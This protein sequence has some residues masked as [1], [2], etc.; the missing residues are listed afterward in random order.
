VILPPPATPSFQASAATLVPLQIEII[1]L[2][3][4]R[5]PS[6]GLW[7]V[8]EVVNR[9]HLTAEN[10][11]LQ[12]GLSDV[13][14]RGIAAIMTWVTPGIIG[15]EIKAPFGVLV[16]G[17]GLDANTVLA[18]PSAAVI[19]GQTLVDAGNR[20]LDLAVIEP[21][22]TIEE[23]QVAVQGQIENTGS[24]RADNILLVTT[25]YDALGNVT[26]FHELS[27]DF[28]LEPGERRPFSFVAAPPGGQVVEF[29]FLAQGL[30]N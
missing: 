30:K 1:N 23:I 4:Y 27:L 21:A 26:G 3:A 14:G 22:A 15:P 20:Y 5:T 29:N 10:I 16:P 28:S 8:G 6:G 12:I 2:N 7:L 25:F 13:N 18:P 11:Q 9:S 17:L 19:G 24:E